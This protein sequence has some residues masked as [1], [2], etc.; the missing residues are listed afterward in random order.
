[1]LCER[2]VLGSLGTTRNLMSGRGELVVMLLPGEGGSSFG[3][4]EELNSRMKSAKQ[5]P[6]TC[7]YKHLT[8]ICTF[9]LFARPDQLLRQCWERE[10]CSFVLRISEGLRLKFLAR[11][12]KHGSGTCAWAPFLLSFGTVLLAAL[13]LSTTQWKTTNW[14]FACLG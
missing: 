2:M 13:R 5:Q 4:S 9:V 1:M 10:T 8:F 6:R 14:N 7:S 12:R 11:C 3:S